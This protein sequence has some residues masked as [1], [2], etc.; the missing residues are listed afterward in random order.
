VEAE[1]KISKQGVRGAEYSSRGF[2][3]VM[4]QFGGAQG[5]TVEKSSKRSVR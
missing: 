5:A 1:A 2:L 3:S 4:H